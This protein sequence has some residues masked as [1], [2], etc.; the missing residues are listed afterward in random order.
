M[1][2]FGLVLDNDYCLTL[3]VDV[4]CPSDI[5]VAPTPVKTIPELFRSA[6]WVLPTTGVAELADRDSLGWG[7]WRTIYVLSISAWRLQQG[8][9][10]WADRHGGLSST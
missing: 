9:V 5:S 10:L 4:A 8:G 6:F 1:M 2:R 3:S 7:Q